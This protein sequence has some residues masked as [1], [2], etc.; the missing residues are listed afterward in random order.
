MLMTKPLEAQADAAPTQQPRVVL[1]RFGVALFDDSRE[2]G[3]A[4]LP[5][6]EAMRFR[7]PQ[8][9]RSDS[10]WVCSADG[11]Q[12][13]RQWGRMH[14][15]RASDYV[16]KLA[17]IASDF[18]V[19]VGTQGR[20]GSVAQKACEILA[21]AI[22][23]A[24]V[25]ATQVYNWQDPQSRLS[26]RTLQDA[27]RTTLHEEV[28]P[29]VVKTNLKAP[30]LSAFQRTSTP[31]WYSNVFVADRIM[32]TLR[33]NRLEYA[34][35]ILATPVPEGAWFFDGAEVRTGFNCTLDQALDPEQP[36]L[37]NATVEFQGRD[38]D[39]ACLTAFG[40]AAG[41]SNTLRTW[42]SQPE[43]AWLSKFARINI[44]GIY[45]T[46]SSREL[47]VKV[48][49]PELL[50]IDPLFSLSISAGLVAEAHW[51][52]L[53]SPIYKRGVGEEV[54]PWSVWLRAMD[55]A[56]SFQLAL[57]AH[58]AGFQVSYYGNGSCLVV[59][60]RQSLPKLVDFALENDI[61]HPSFHPIFEENGL[62]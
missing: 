23:R 52:A 35:R 12:F 47:P 11:A 40:S 16:S 53:A 32:I 5:D 17:H 37:V 36:C 22:H 10:I 7:S 3:W 55:R 45:H 20:F 30:L 62:I 57:A 33:Y 9:L 8:D 51:K 4:S 21:P 31:S 25:I 41:R 59:V 19:K 18:G 44:H 58:Q 27:L 26:E 56:L 34:K 49:L 54:N 48:Q 13:M 50:T 42:I 1:P 60:D 24:M 14:H 28:A 38:P 61:M 46:L 15:L 39:L 6:G 2:S 29:P 43:L